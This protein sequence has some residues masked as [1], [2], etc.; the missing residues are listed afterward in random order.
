[1]PK[2]KREAKEGA[3]KR[4]KSAYMMFSIDKRPEISKA[5]PNES[6]GQLGKLLGQAW[7]EVTS[8]E[9]EKYNALAAKDKLRYQK[10]IAEYR[11]K[12]PNP[13]SSSDD[14]SDKK[15][16]R[17][18]KKK[19][20]KDPNAP[21]KNVSAFLHFSNAIRPRI[22]AENPTA[23]FGEIGKLIGQAWASVD[24]QEKEKYEEMAKKDRE[25]YDTASK[26]YAAKKKEEGSS[27][28]EDSDSESPSE[29]SD[30][31]SSDESD[32]E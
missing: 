11:A 8:D 18:R 21:K 23:K 19:K 10:E 27:D 31:E 24:P 3:P 32:S 14:E 17:K 22:K 7:K 2:R 12:Y 29:S 25:R 4:P 26:A 9:K 15:G 28:S 5:H 20:K 6:F 13:S 30:S 16:K 1:M